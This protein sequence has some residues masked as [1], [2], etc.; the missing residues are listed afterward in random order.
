MYKV[1]HYIT[2]ETDQPLDVWMEPWGDGFTLS[3][4]A[5]VR[6][7][8]QSEMEGD[9]HIEYLPNRVMIYGWP[10]CTLQVNS[11]PTDEL[12]R[13]FSIPFPSIPS[14][15]SMKEFITLLFGDPPPPAESKAKQ[16]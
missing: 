6:L 3:P 7:V 15:L 13:D 16:S 9:L 12:I 2:N 10:G 1:T 11:H 14:G 4:H 8:G 5:H